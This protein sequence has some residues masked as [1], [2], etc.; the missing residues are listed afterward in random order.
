MIKH[1]TTITMTKR[2]MYKLEVS[3]RPTQD[4][5]QRMRDRHNLSTMAKYLVK[6]L[7]HLPICTAESTPDIFACT[8]CKEIHDGMTA[9]MK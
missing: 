8:I 3:T 5:E 1:C 4:M 6:H 7:N 2:T 9:E